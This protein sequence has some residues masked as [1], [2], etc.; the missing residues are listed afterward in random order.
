MEESKVLLNV[1]CLEDELKDAELLNEMLV[2][3]GYLV[4]MDIA[5]EE[6]E[7]LSFLKG[8]NYDIILADYTLPG[9]DVHAA[10]KLALAL[11]PE[12]PFICASGTIGEDKAVELLKLGA[13]D[14]VFKDR[15]GRLAFAVRQ[16]LEGVEKQKERKK[17][18][19]A[20]RDANWRLESVI[21]G[22][23]VGTWIF[24]VQTSELVYNE[25]WAKV[26]GYSLDE[27]KS[28]GITVKKLMVNPE[29]LKKS[30]E[31][32][33]KHIAGGIYNYEFE[34]QIK[35]KDGHN[36]WVYDYGRV[37]TR[38]NEGKALLM[39]GTLKDI[40]ERKQAEEILR[41][42]ESKFRILF[43]SANDSIFL[44]D[45]NI[46]IDCNPKAL[47]I[48][49]CT[50]EQIIGQHPCRFSPEVQPDGR[51]SMEKAQEKIE[52]ALRGQPQFFEWKHSRYDG[53]LFDTE[54][55]LNAFSSMGKYY[56]QSVVRDIT[57]RKR[58][59]LELKKS[60]EK[61]RSFISQISEGVYRYECDQPMDLDLPIE[62]QIDF[63]YD[64][65][66]TAEC[67]NSLLKMYRIDDQKDIIG[68]GPLDFH[69]GRHNLVNRG[70]VR[71]F[72]SNGYHI[73]NGIT[74][75][76][77]TLGQS[78]YISNNALGIFEN[79]QLVRVWGTQIDI[80][81]RKRAEQEL[82]LANEALLQSEK[83]FRRSISESPM[84]IRIVSVDG[85]IIYANRAFLEIF[86]CNSLDEF[87]SISAIN[88]YTP[89]SYAQHQE[90]KEK[91]KNGHEVFDYE[92][93]IVR[94]TAEIRH[95]KVTRKDVLWNG[96]KHYQVINQDITEQKKLTIDLIEAK[97]HAEESDRLKTAF[98]AN[99]SHEIRTPMNGILGFANLLKE[100]N[101][102]GEEQQ[103][104]IKIIEKSGERMLNII[105]D[106]VDISKIEANLIQVNTI[107]TEINEKLEYI[108]T[109]F[110]PQVAEKGLQIFFKN[111]FP[112][113]KVNIK[114]D[115][116]KFYSIIA[117]LI[118]NAIKFTDQGKIEF[119]Y[120][121]KEDYLEFYVKDTG[122]GIPKE[123]QEAI[124]ERFI[125]ADIAD[126]MARQG[127][128]LGLSISKAYVEMLGG[129]IWVESEVGIGSIFYFTL[130]HNT[131]R[132]DAREITDSNANVKKEVPI[133]PEVSGLK[134]L[135]VEDDDASK[136][137]ISIAVKKLCKALLEVNT[138]AEAVDICRNNPDIDLILMDIQ[139]PEMNG[140]EATR[141]IRQFN[142]KVVIIAQTAFGLRGDREKAIEA[143]C[144]D[145]IAKPIIKDELV[146]LIQK[147]FKK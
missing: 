28:N 69:G 36:I 132:Q 64:H 108:Y 8:R 4:N 46:F 97:E 79:N 110:K 37:V 53:T 111:A 39:L 23:N 5:A 49:G 112:T 131:A 99:M 73:E 11:Q 139:I 96:I 90:R 109:F 72:I 104:Y 52:A 133:N 119:G 106:I 81:E 65:M 84:G 116:D 54:V 115:T 56:L 9:F 44:M 88:R 25:L 135:V 122:I 126:K 70:H 26:I 62:E 45:Q 91:R 16:A 6:K 95:V 55:S 3:A 47:E 101:L 30:D 85:K 10:L 59:E 138:G 118:K 128:G 12:V 2:D 125:Q 130:P 67:N 105:N 98:L 58:I 51:K 114:T 136:K 48:F 38:T 42:S 13:T 57:E 71:K 74:E 102:S 31:L 80:T 7:Y 143:G 77:N 18:E 120:R 78:M 117:N 66:F 107:E 83:N 123:R 92:I 124:F 142:K 14:Y 60:E 1:L 113:K 63:F 93:S 137:F 41:E 19:E 145:Y 21:E 34:C 87:L 129:K 68:K 61:Y 121:L 76:F 134:I 86:D 17:A 100:A 20:L 33:E 32:C 144:N 82:I 103:E 89:E 27:I 43:E 35:H 24:N 29:D 50:R 140:Y 75:E 146:T 141:Q 147:Y 22:A 40:T 94:A 15:L 127:A